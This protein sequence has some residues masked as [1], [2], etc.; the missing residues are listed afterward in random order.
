M[1]QEQES[2]SSESESELWQPSLEDE[3]HDSDDP[4]LNLIEPPQAPIDVEEWVLP[5]SSA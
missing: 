3:E 1:V 2:S 4:E 5:Q